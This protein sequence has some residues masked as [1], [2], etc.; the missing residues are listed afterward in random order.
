VDRTRR[1]KEW[2]GTARRDFEANRRGP[3]PNNGTGSLL[4]QLGY[5]L[6]FVGIGMIGYLAAR[7]LSKGSRSLV[8]GLTRAHATSGYTR[9]AR[10]MVLSASAIIRSVYSEYI[11]TD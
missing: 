3:P 6:G 7:A 1:R 5:L 4:L 10:A 2:N 8:R 9:L 11:A